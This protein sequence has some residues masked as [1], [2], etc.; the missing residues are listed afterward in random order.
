MTYRQQAKKNDFSRKG[1][2]CRKGLLLL[3]GVCMLFWLAGCQAGLD[4]ESE[5]MQQSSPSAVE[6]KEERQ[7]YLLQTFVSDLSEWSYLDGGQQEQISVSESDWALPGYEAGGWNVGTG[8]FGAKNGTLEPL[9]EEHRAE[10]LLNQYQ[11]DGDNVPTFFFRTTFQVEDPADIHML[12]GE[13]AYDD[14][15]ILYLNGEVIFEG[16]VPEEGFPDRFSYGAAVPQGSPITDSFQVSAELL[17]EGENVL[18]AELHQSD[19]SSSD[20][21]FELISLE[22]VIG[23]CRSAFVG[24][25]ADGTSVS[26]NWIQEGRYSEDAGVYIQKVGTS[27]QA[28]LFPATEVEANDVGYSYRTS[29]TGLTEDVRYSYSIVSGG[30]KI[31]EGSFRT[32]SAEDGIDILLLGDPQLGP[33]DYMDY[34]DGYADVLHDASEDDIDFAVCLGDVAVN[35][36]D[37]PIYETAINCLGSVDVPIA[38]IFGNHDEAD[39]CLSASINLPNMTEYASLEESGD[40]SGDYWFEYG[41]SLFL[42][43]NSN[44][45]DS[46]QHQSFM[47][48]AEARYRDSYGEP[49]WRVVLMHHALFSQG[50]NN[51][52][53]DVLTL[54]EELAPV[55]SERNIDVVFSGHDHTYSRSYLMQGSKSTVYEGQEAVREEGEVLYVSLNSSTGAKYYDLTARQPYTAFCE[56]NYKAMLTRVNITPRRLHIT[57]WEPGTEE[58]IDEFTLLK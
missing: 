16:N 37:Y 14:A 17:R 58:I 49:A 48:E 29:V 9:S 56:Q 52:K 45:T 15:V 44:V 2:P 26:L 50:N 38:M 8:S 30:N 51:E 46:L 27:E 55:F 10:T 5:A 47:E 43:L 20:I 25:G 53:D 3:I 18:A 21:Y 31:R 54:R 42:C 57:T 19:E 23:E 12:Q 24:I 32:G 28:V 41:E 6:Q 35:A 33:D 4:D 1:F 13:V 36:W 22:S 39:D 11:E 7:E 34:M 40:M